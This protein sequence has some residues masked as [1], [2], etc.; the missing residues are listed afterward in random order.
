MRKPSYWPLVEKSRAACLAAIET[1]NRAS[2]QYREE[3]FAILMIN[4]WELLLKARV[5]KE[6][7][8]K[9]SSLHA[10]SFKKKKDGKPGKKK[11]FRFTRS[12]LHY[13]ISLSTCCET[14]RAYAVD[15]IDEPCIQNIDALVEM[16]DSAVHFVA[17]N[18]RLRK[19]LAELSLASVRNYVIA[20]QKWFDL[21]F[22]DLNIAS[23][24]V[25]FDLDQEGVE[26]IARKPGAAVA[27]FLAHIQEME[28]E[29]NAIVSPF[30]FSVKVSFDLLK[31]KGDGAVMA[32]LAAPGEKADVVMQVDGDGLPAGFE[33]SYADLVRHLNRRYVNF[34]AGKK[35]LAAMKDL[36]EDK[37][38]CFER[39]LDP[40]RKR[41]TIKRFYNPNIL[42][43]FDKIHEV[44]A[45][46]IPAAT[47][48]A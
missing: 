9:V 7:G 27:K 42:K 23:I 26:A 22:S 20:S 44:R 24:P 14:V 2:V 46:R 31:K 4:A 10:Y 47:E 28:N 41:G 33:W 35:F 13:T 39:Y 32:R 25:T 18:Q 3:T 45:A 48:A 43:H 11:E 37:G 29:T 34:S 6:S 19:V 21:S 16:R 36:K 30:T 5:M 12:K 38:I 1:Y 15:A 40:K 8:G 17:N